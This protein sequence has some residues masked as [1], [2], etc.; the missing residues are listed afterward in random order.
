MSKTYLE[1]RFFA[2]T[3]IKQTCIQNWQFMESIT[4]EPYGLP[5]YTYRIA[6]HGER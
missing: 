5:V 2:I 3:N 1:A 6:Y 4:L